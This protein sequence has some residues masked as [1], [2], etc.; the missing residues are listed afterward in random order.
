MLKF[1]K[2]SKIYFSPSGTTEKIVN[3]VAKHF[4]LNRENYN[5]LSFDEEKTFT[6]ELVIIG[7][8]VL[9]EES[10][11]WFAKGFQK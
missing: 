1:K 6:D 3:E 8:P 5:L 11:N 9:T 10:L 4:N 2:L 7:V